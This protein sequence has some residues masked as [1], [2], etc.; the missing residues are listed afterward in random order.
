MQ[1]LCL[2]DIKL[3]ECN[4]P[5]DKE[6]EDILNHE[7]GNLQGYDC[8]VCRNRGFL[9]HVDGGEKWT[10][11][12]A[13]M[14]KRADIVRMRKS[15]LSNLAAKCT[16]KSFETTDDWQKL[17][18]DTAKAYLADKDRGWLYVAGQTGCGKTHLCTA[19][20]VKMLRAGASTRYVRWGELVQQARAMRFDADDYSK[21]LYPLK[22]CK[23]LY[24]DDLLKTQG[25]KQPSEQEYQVAMEIINA[26][27]CDPAL[28]TI[29]STELTLTE[30]FAIDEA[31]AGRI[32]ERASKYTL[33]IAKK[34][35]R[36][37][38]L[39]FAGVQV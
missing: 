23:V 29:I 14:Q 12:C 15:G 22:T 26:R 37:Y 33:Q 19:V 4:N 9:W 25:N 21:L 11:K 10:E 32:A 6:L 5:T 8:P 2:R 34:A 16:L 24:I 39:R 31:L 1:R 38:R 30:L 3:S 28:L 36:N 7:D 27:Y 18:L 35:G 13:C 20:A 17:M